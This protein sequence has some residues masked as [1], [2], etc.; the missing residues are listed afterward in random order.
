MNPPDAAEAWRL[1]D[2]EDRGLRVLLALAEGKAVR[3]WCVS[4]ADASEL[5]GEVERLRKQLFPDVSL[6]K[7]TFQVQD[8]SDKQEEHP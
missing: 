2:L 8:A 4:E 1:F 3:A 6:A 7:V 5:R